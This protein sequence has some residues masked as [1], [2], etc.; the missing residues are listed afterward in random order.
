M[1]LDYSAELPRTR[2]DLS[3]RVAVVTGAARGIGRS[4]ALAFAWAGAEVF[5][6]DIDLAG[7]QAV[8]GQIQQTG[9]RASFIPTDV[10]SED[11]VAALFARASAG[12]GLDFLLNNA[13]IA[14]AGAA[15][16]FSD[17]LSGFDQ[18]LAVNLRG[19]FLCARAAWPHMQKRQAAIINISS[20]RALMSEAGSEAY[21]A[22]KGGL[23]SLTHS[24]AVSLAPYQIRV[25]CISPGWID[26]SGVYEQISQADHEQHP[27]GRVGLPRDVAA[28]CLW[29]CSPDASFVTGSNLVLDGGMTKKMIYL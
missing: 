18:V 22:A 21:A 25:N 16:I 15:S 24:L 9:G 29:L 27:A 7:G 23:L 4:L 19:P 20:T 13:A 17:D 6:A 8:A 3:G 28:A 5:L 2:P 11:Q 14:N 12:G 26:T 1:A 10:S